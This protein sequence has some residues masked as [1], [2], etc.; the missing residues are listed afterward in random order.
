MIIF[1]LRSVWKGPQSQEFTE[2]SLLSCDI[3]DLLKNGVNA[4]ITVLFEPS[5][6]SSLQ[7]Y[8]ETK[9]FLIL[10][11]LDNVKEKYAYFEMDESTQQWV[12]RG[13]EPDGV[14]RGSSLS[15]LDAYR[16]DLFWVTTN[17]FTQVQ[18][19]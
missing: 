5:T 4:N 13:V 9:N 7:G 12:S 16:S 19:H 10:E 11:I 14:I 3:I 18:Y 2:G 6:T 8:T 17:S 15:A 1:R